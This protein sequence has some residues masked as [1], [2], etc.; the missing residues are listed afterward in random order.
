MNTIR[1]HFDIGCTNEQIPD[2]LDG[3][4]ALER[5]LKLQF[6]WISLNWAGV[7]EVTLPIEDDIMFLVMAYAELKEFAE[8]SQV[9][10]VVLGDGLLEVT[11]ER[12][13]EVVTMTVCHT[14]HLDRRFSNSKTIEVDMAA[15]QRAWYKMAGE[16]AQQL[17][18]PS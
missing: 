17:E 15:Y 10:R 11:A 18:I 9:H 4:S 6:R 5:A 7:V 1:L 13:G 16:L 8:G 3:E 12:T 14:P 2:M